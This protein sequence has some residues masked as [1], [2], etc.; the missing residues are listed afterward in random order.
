MRNTNFAIT[1]PYIFSP[2]SATSAE[3][4]SYNLELSF[5]FYET[6]HRYF[7]VFFKTNIISYHYSVRQVSFQ[8]LE[9]QK[10]PIFIMNIGNLY[11][12]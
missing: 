8:I 4:K 2:K 1:L 10:F 3:S 5:S 9:W 7:L 12:F 6:L 11:M